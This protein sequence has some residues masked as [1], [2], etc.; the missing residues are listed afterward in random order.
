MAKEAVGAGFEHGYTISKFIIQSSFV[1]DASIS[2]SVEYRRRVRIHSA[3][4][5]S[6]SHDNGWR[7][8]YNP[9]VRPTAIF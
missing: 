3:A 9:Q 7:Y 2:S 4:T 8:E 6:L 1:S 5:N